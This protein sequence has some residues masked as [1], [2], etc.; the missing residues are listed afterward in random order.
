M[1][2]NFLRIAIAIAFAVV[3]CAM[4]LAQ[5]VSGSI[6]GVVT[7]PSG[8]VI[9]GA[10]VV[11]TN[12]DTGVN[13][14]ATSNAEG[15]YRILLLPIGRYQLAVNA[16]GFQ[17]GTVAPFD[18]EALQ[19]ATVNLKLTVGNT[20][21]TVSVSAAAPIL[22]TSD[23]TLGS[24]FTAN[25]VQN[26][27]LNGLDF[28]ALTLYVPGAVS[29]FGTSGTTVIERSTFYSD[30]VN[31]NGNRAQANN[32]TLDGIDLNETFNNLISYSPAPE[33]LAEIKVLTANSPVE[34]GNVNGGGVASVLKS[35]TN[36]FHGSAYGLVQ[37]YRLNANTFANN[38]QTPR[39]PISP[40]SQDQF[41]GSFGG[42]IKHDK[43]FFFVD[44]LGSR[45]HS[46]GT[47]TASVL[48]QAERNGDFSA[49]LQ[50]SNPIQLYDPQNNFAPYANNQ[51]IPVVNPVAKF[52]IANPTLYPLPN[53]TPTDGITANN[54]Q[55][56]TRNFKSNNQGDIKIEWDPREKDKVT[57]FFSISTAFDGNIA[58][59]PIT[60]PGA[61]LYPTKVTGANWVHT[62]SP[63]LL[64]SVHIGF[65]R[66]NW[67]QGFPIDTTGQFGT[68]GNQKVGIPFPDQRFN[69][70]TFQNL[71]GGLTGVGSPALDGGLIDNT[72]S[73]ID[74]VTWERGRNLVTVGGQA[75]RY[76]NNYP[77]SNNDGYLGS[78]IYNGQFT[79]NPSVSNAGGY[80]AADFLLDRV[81]GAQ[82]TLS[83]VNVGQRQWRAA[84][85]INDDYKLTPNLTIN[86]GVRYEY[87]QPWEEENNKTGNIDE[88]TGQV[89][90]AVR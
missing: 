66:T 2:R 24:T 19:T 56:P 26:F 16:P 82:A 41:G 27:P 30:S 84:G 73:Y 14:T 69:G 11:A 60:F 42:P 13:T 64:N 20:A 48:T 51:G 50:G 61:N 33:S 12:V 6:T 81:S 65:T 72:F 87:D 7:D 40:Y 53:A 36:R 44:Y 22:D 70:F 74:N 88:A 25:T 28:S 71:G 43:L 75:L 76:E 85:Y 55:A 15:L 18:L 83:S 63:A 80:G 1:K 52:L 4:V 57:G 46:G 23:P 9:S 49:L 32:Y 5:K 77:T 8:A 10:S 67:T 89:L 68:T 47:G 39:I 54:Y 78:L 86:L 79:S 45:N 58:V 34:F 38:N 35:G 21:T 90:Y 31:L 62:F 37:D 59:L 17:S 29:T 3:P